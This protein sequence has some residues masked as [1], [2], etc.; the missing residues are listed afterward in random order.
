MNL[1]IDSGNSSTKVA[2][3]EHERLTEKHVFT[4][5]SELKSYLSNA[6]A[7]NAI[8]SSV[9]E[10]MDEMLSWVAHATHKIKLQHQLPLPVTIRYSTPQTLGLDRIASV[11]GA[12]QLFPAQ[13]T[14]VIDAGTCIT[15]DFVDAHKNY[16][17]G[18]ISPGLAMRFN[19]VHTFTAKLPLTKPM[20]YPEL[21]GSTTEQCIQS[22]IVLG[23]IDE[24]NGVIERYRIKYPHLQVI[25]CGGDTSFFENKLKASIFACPNLVLIGLNCILLHNVSY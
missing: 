10:D 23:T 13:D 21:I 12:I 9:K 24:L 3:F 16:P 15:Y 6:K 7:T 5:S 25:L 18:G 2:I 8:V 17:G 11:C 20:E 19:A 4:S 22:G 1:V 14:L